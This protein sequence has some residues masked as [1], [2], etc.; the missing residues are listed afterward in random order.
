[1]ASFPQAHPISHS[2]PQQSSPSST[3]PS[4]ATDK[5]R[6]MTEIAT[7]L[8]EGWKLI[9]M[10]CPMPGCKTPLVSAPTH[11]GG[12]M[13]C[14]S[15]QAPVLREGESLPPPLS[16]A[17]AP[18][19]AALSPPPFIPSP[20]AP[21]EATSS[22]V[23]GLQE[24]PKISIPR[25]EAILST[26]SPSSPSLPI[27]FSPP[28]VTPLTPQNTAVGVSP[29]PSSH[30]FLVPGHARAN[31]VEGEGGRERGGEGGKEGGET[32][33]RIVDT[34]F[35]APACRTETDVA[36][37]QVASTLSREKRRENASAATGQRLLQGW[38]MGA[39][40]CPECLV[41]LMR[42]GG[43]GGG[44]GGGQEEVWECV[45][46]TTR[47]FEGGGGGEGSDGKGGRGRRGGG[48]RGR[49]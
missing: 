49:D 14:V 33:N 40:S 37:A 5:Q 42:E 3:S 8:Q 25:P 48:G 19:A 27:T 21:K 26:S 13:Y 7:R 46:C 32:V 4:G 28:P 29:T 18:A 20:A 43:R 22:P 36:I 16:L 30:P 9:S 2:N 45:G 34:I 1:M 11:D 12:Q 38:V 39:E 23:Q 15:C 6:I 44:V 35:S 10:T 24:G 47:F 41:P 17:T 31:G